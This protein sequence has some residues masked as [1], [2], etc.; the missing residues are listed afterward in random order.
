MILVDNGA[1][2]SRLMTIRECARLMGAP[3]S[4]QLNGSYND[5][6][7][8]MGDAVVVPVTRWLTRNLLAPALPDR[9]K[10]NRLQEFSVK[11]CGVRY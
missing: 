8:A 9:A 4:Y 7:R 3:D 2:R 1:V 10:S 6:Y 5:G 11:K